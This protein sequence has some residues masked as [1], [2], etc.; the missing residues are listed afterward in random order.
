M[1]LMAQRLTESIYSGKD[2]GHLLNPPATLIEFSLG[3]LCCGP[4]A[5]SAP[6]WGVRVFRPRDKESIIY[7]PHQ[8]VSICFVSLLYPAKEHIS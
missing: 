2:I 8:S 1:G 4:Q 3:R 7:L 5:D 6:C